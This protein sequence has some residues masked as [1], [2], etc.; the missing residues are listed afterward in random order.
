[1]T[2]DGAR[3]EVVEGMV[4]ELVTAGEVDLLALAQFLGGLVFKTGAEK[5][6]FR[7]RFAMYND[8]LEDSWTFQEFKHQ[9][10]EK[11]LAEGLEKGLE[12]GLEKGRQEGKL[13]AQ[14]QIL[15]DIVLDQFPE[16]V[17]LAKKQVDT[18]ENPDW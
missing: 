13:E 11:G 10:L 15:L 5:E 3:R 18:V 2:K 7:K 4:T 9:F 8:I 1:L 14:R 16:L 6:W 12:R 17:N